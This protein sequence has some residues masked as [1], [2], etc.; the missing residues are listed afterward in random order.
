VRGIQQ[1]CPDFTL[2]AGNITSVTT[3]CRMLDGLP[4][5]LELGGWWSLLHTPGQ[6]VDQLR[7]D[8]F[9]L[10]VGHRTATT[11]EPM[12]IV[13]TL[14]RTI[15][16]LADDERRFLTRMSSADRDWSIEDAVRLA[17]IDATTAARTIHELLLRGLLRRTEGVTGPD[18]RFQ[19]LN[20]I[21][22][23]GAVVVPAR[24]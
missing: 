2:D 1:M 6:L 23:L 4:G 12:D 16:L 21:R 14:R 22:M 13:E 18:P 3:L 9:P 19:V 11:A 5:G 20:L 17:G 7:S 8:P 15:S 10:L 24:G